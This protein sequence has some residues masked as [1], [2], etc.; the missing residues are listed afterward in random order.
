MNAAATHA[1]I[2]SPV[3]AAG[4][5]L[6]FLHIP[7]TAG[8]A[9]RELFAA[10]FGE[11]RVTR[12]LAATPLR[13]ALVRHARR[14][15]ICGHLTTEHGDVLPSDRACVTV[16]RDPVDRF[17]SYFYFR[18]FDAAQSPIDPRVRQLELEAYVDSLGVPDRPELNLQTTMLYPLG[19]DAQS[20]V[21]WDDRVAAAMRALD[22]FDH[23]GVQEELED[24]A[25]MLGARFGRSGDA[26]RRAN[27]TS[28]RQA[29]ADVPARTRLRLQE[30]LQYDIAV[31]EH[32][33]ALFRRQRRAALSVAAATPA[34]AARDA[35]PPAPAPVPAPRE[36][37]DRRAEI[38]RVSVQGELAGHALAMVGEAVHLH[39]DFLAHEALEELSVAFVIRD[40]HD[41]PVFGTGTHQL[42]RVV[43]VSPGSYRATFSFINRTEPGHYVVDA[44]L[45]RNASHLQGCHH[46]KERA[47][48]FD[49]V[50]WATPWF[51]GRVMMDAAVAFASLSPAGRIE[52]RPSSTAVA[53]PVF[54]IGRLNPALDDFSARLRVVGALPRQLHAGTELALE[55]E[56]AN[57]GAQAWRADGKQPVC[58][59]YH[60][61][62]ARGKVVEYDGLRT[63][64]PR[65]LG[66]GDY[67][68]LCGL[69]RAPQ[70]A[71][72]MRLVWT[73]VQ[74]GVAWFDH[75]DPSACA[76]CEVEVL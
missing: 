57:T 28:R 7:K 2:A 11:D 3:A 8:T 35:A 70:A 16:L 43:G 56:L 36:F 15:V 76:V 32:A 23:V 18:K 33:L 26:L 22:R 59:S 48:A 29:A 65:D 40:E 12:N 41:L 53:P 60:W 42:G 58:L 13:E 46:W 10:W 67:L 9:L 71:G 44:S 45:V 66:P 17:L 24:F 74:E 49:V 5:R 6:L 37:G 30:L 55:L 72:P 19:T 68:R 51:A 31:H 61:L 1:D 34:P 39:V 4:D 69:L 62:D 38:T 14:D 27:V 20:I 25:C 52:E 75:R 54:S 63:R 73:L 50:G 47:T 64:L 21:P